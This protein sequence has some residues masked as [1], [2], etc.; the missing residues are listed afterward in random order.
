MHGVFC[1]KKEG[2]GPKGSC[3]AYFKSLNATSQKQD[4]S[5]GRLPVVGWGTFGGACNADGKLRNLSQ[6]LLRLS[7][8]RCALLLQRLQQSKR[9]L[10]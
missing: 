8:G 5:S 7:R 6:C 2:C 4:G 10:A 1:N 3:T 9:A